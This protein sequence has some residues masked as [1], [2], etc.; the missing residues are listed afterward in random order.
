[1]RDTS[2]VNVR[3]V[4]MMSWA[5]RRPVEIDSAIR[6]RRTLTYAVYHAGNEEISIDY[7]R[8]QR[9]RSGRR[10]S[11]GAGG[12]ASRDCG[13]ARERAGKNPLAGRQRSRSAGGAR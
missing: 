12:L 6:S 13:Q 10:N 7:G 11:T 8:R 1:M 5:D 4:V 3:F 9:D 2:R